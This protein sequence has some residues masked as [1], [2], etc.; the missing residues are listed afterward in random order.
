MEIY[1]KI[2]G[3]SFWNL[4]APII[5]RVAAGMQADLQCFKAH[6]RIVREEKYILTGLHERVFTQK[7]YKK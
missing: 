4:P 2:A 3:I 5:V 6:V 1:A 7:V